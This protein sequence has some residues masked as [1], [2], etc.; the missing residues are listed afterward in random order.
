MEKT[1]RIN[2][3][4]GNKNKFIDLPK[5]ADIEQVYNQMNTLKF[6]GYTDIVLGFTPFFPVEQYRLLERLLGVMESLITAIELDDTEILENQLAEMKIF[7]SSIDESARELSYVLEGMKGTILDT[8]YPKSLNLDDVQS[9]L[10]H[11]NSSNSNL[12]DQ[13]QDR[14]IGYTN[15]YDVTMTLKGQSINLPMNADLYTGLDAL[16]R[17]ELDYSS[18]ISPKL[19]TFGLDANEGIAFEGYTLGEKWNGWAMPYFTKD[20]AILI[21]QIFNNNNKDKE[22]YSSSHYDPTN[23]TFEFLLFGQTEEEKEKYDATELCINGVI[24]KVYQ[25]GAGSWTWDEIE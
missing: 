7:G 8:S 16:I 3:I 4:E 25:I 15:D 21:T 13:L 6:E 9:F 12:M 2:Y 22:D 24:T 20:Q 5:G 19:T 18:T 17:N 10:K 1:Y 14:K 11:M 23:D